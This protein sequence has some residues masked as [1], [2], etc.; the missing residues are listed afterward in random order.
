MNR[1]VKHAL[2]AAALLALPAWGGVQSQADT[3]DWSQRMSQGDV[4]RV[5][6]IVG[7]IRATLAPG[8]EV[9]VVAR[10]HGDSG[11]F[12]EVAIEV[13]EMDD[14]YV[15]CA[16]YGSWRHGQGRCHPDHRNRDDDRDDRR[17]RH[18]NIDVEVEYEVRVPAGVEFH[19]GMVSGGIQVRDLRSDVD[20]STVNGD[21]YA[22]TSGRAWAN[23]VSGDIEVEM[24]SLAWDEMDY[25]T[26][27]GDITL[28][29]PHD[30][31]ADLRFNS[32]SGD[33]RSDF[34][35]ILQGRQ[36]RRW[37]GSNIRGTIGDGGRDLNVQ[38]VSGNLDL[39]RM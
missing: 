11:D 15:I 16:V 2:L 8:N 18:N 33:L 4:L 32:I 22:S 13:E 34:D 23:T 39:R 38:T 36:N 20:L 27:S 24:G 9:E 1:T 6:G 31:G 35:L 26:V 10:K 30:F 12:Q 29:L 3:F 19:G 21:I 7:E 28:W 25:N 14:G 5:K 37:V 17:N